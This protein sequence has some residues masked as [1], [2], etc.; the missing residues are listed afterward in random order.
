[1]D[2]GLRGIFMEN[3][4]NNGE[5]VSKTRGKTKFVLLVLFLFVL[6]ASGVWFWKNGA[7]KLTDH[8]TVTIT[9]P[10]VPEQNL[11]TV[12]TVIP[13]D[14]RS[15]YFSPGPISMDLIKKNGCVADGLLSGYGDRPDAL[16]KMIN[17][18]KCVYLHRALETWLKPPDFDQAFEVMKKITQRPLV[19]GMFLA[20]AVSTNRTYSDPAEGKKFHFDEMCRDGT[21][22]RWGDNTCIPSVENVEY[23]RYLKAVTHRAMDLGIQSFL[24]GQLQFQDEK[25]NFKETDIRKVID[26]MRQYAK[27]KNLD[28]IIGGQT[29]NITDEKYLRLFDYIE[30]GVGIDSQGNVEDQ[31]CFSGHESCWALLWDKTYSAK[32]NNVFL[33]LDWSGMTWDDMGIFARMSKDMR[34]QTLQNLYQKFTS[35]NMGFMMPYLAVLNHDNDGCYGPNKGFYAPSK[36]FGCKDESAMNKIMPSIS[37]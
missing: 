30:G 29:N 2:W 6:G 22:G 23:R 27:E 5:I 4:N 8:K 26:D 34:A 20:E 33:H 35:Q 16:T 9:N 7:K 1:M 19:Y 31:P 18:S 28:I 17:K 24:F 37:Q 10:V 12:Y 15:K 11:D 13:D 36:K 21:K 3:Y 32:A 14:E 25:P